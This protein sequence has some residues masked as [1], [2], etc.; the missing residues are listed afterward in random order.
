MKLYTLISKYFQDARDQIYSFAETSSC[1]Y[2][3]VVF[4]KQLCSHPSFRP[5]PTI[6]HEIVCYS[7]DPHKE[8]P[9]PK[10][11]LQLERESETTMERVGLITY[12]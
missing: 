9:K 10:Q 1:T 7:K 6:D 12:E 11:L 4:T 8:Y 2:E 5:L 3:M